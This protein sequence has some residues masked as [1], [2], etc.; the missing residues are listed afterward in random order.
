MSTSSPPMVSH[1]EPRLWKIGPDEGTKRPG[2][3]RHE[4]IQDGITA[5][6]REVWYYSDNGE[7]A[8]VYETRMPIDDLVHLIVNTTAEERHHFTHQRT[9]EPAVSWAGTPSSGPPATPLA[10]ITGQVSFEAHGFDLLPECQWVDLAPAM[11]ARWAAVER[12]AVTTFLTNHGCEVQPSPHR[13]DLLPE[14]IV[15]IGGDALPMGGRVVTAWS[16][17]A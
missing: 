7:E 9:K 12:A 16:A 1:D 10:S 11:K 3:T 14:V 6:V 8:Q 17:V 2:G 13:S 15:Q 4:I 5:V